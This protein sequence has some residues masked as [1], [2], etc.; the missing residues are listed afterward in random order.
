MIDTSYLYYKTSGGIYNDDG[1]GRAH[2]TNSHCEIFLERKYEY[3]DI[4]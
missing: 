2:T 4:K 3:E 1:D